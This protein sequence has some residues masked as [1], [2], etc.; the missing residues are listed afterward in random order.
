MPKKG[1]TKKPLI[2]SANPADPHGLTQSMERYLEWM[3]PW[4]SAGLAL[5]ISGFLVSPF[6]GMV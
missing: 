3:R 4:G 6:L 2:L 1:E 5:K